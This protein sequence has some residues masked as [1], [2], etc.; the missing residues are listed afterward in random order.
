MAGRHDGAA[1][2]V[3]QML[4]DDLWWRATVRRGKFKERV[5]GAV[6]CAVNLVSHRVAHTGHNKVFFKPV[7]NLLCTFG[8][9]DHALT[10]IYTSRL[11]SLWSSVVL[12]S[13]AHLPTLHP[14]SDTGTTS[15]HTDS[16]MDHR[17]DV[18][19]PA[20]SSGLADG[21]ESRSNEASHP[22]STGRHIDEN[23]C[24]ETAS[25]EDDFLVS[26]ADRRLFYTKDYALWFDDHGVTYYH[27]DGATRFD[28]DET[29]LISVDNPTQLIPKRGIFSHGSQIYVDGR[30]FD[31]SA[32]REEV[33]EQLR[34]AAGGAIHE[35]DARERLLLERVKAAD[36]VKNWLD[37]LRWIDDVRREAYNVAGVLA[38]D[39]PILK[40]IERGIGAL[41]RLTGG[42][43]EGYVRLVRP[44]DRLACITVWSD[45]KR[46]VDQLLDM[47]A[48]QL[49][50]FDVIARAA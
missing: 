3:S 39:V 27:E 9:V 33:L 15:R 43:D 2:R 36:R 13:W 44:E 25:R 30:I 14:H 42:T 34:D 20:S 47:G 21:Q 4:V 32:I 18:T 49:W 28:R 48:P 29:G 37:E 12:A 40:S 50:E 16:T 24:R 38:L 31:A 8:G 1:H 17:N 26:S 46:D 5:L 35:A 41:R 23:I 19:G 11:P 6:E 45:L 22:T 7:V 10:R